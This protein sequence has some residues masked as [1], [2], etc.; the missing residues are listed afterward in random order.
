MAASGAASGGTAGLCTGTE[1]FRSWANSLLEVNR[2]I[3]PRPIRSLEL[4]ISETFAPVM[5]RLQSV[6]GSERAKERMGQGVKVQGTKVPGRSCKRTVPGA[7]RLRILGL[8]HF[9][10]T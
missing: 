5:C 1:P 10:A 3:G 9:R 7:K 4:S 2:P 8:V 6:P